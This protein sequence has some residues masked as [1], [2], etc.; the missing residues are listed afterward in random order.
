MLLVNPMLRTLEFRCQVRVPQT[1]S[2]A[3]LPLNSLYNSFCIQFEASVVASFWVLLQ[4]DGWSLEFRFN[5]I[6]KRS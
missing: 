1:Y 5:S 2:F 4:V 6:L 3:L